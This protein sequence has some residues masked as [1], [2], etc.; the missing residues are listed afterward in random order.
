[1]KKLTLLFICLT[2]GLTV[3]L[4]AQT[5]EESKK[6]VQQIQVMGPNMDLEKTLV[7]YG[8]IEQDSDPY[9]FFSFTNTGSEPLVIKHAKGSC[10]CTVPEYAKAPIM[11]G[12]TSEIKVR[13]AT[14]RVGPFTKTIT[15]T[16]NEG[17]DVAG[18]KRVLTIKGKVNAKPVAPAAIPA[19][20]PSIL[21]GGN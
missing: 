15:L 18:K 9:R 5:K 21:N 3:S 10:G 2:M 7:D 20:Q 4:S 14:N 19:S 17:E 11:P 6:S 12:E 8:T 1:M 16:T 13:Y